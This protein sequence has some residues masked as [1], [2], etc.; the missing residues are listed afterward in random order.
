V[1]KQQQQQQQ[2]QASVSAML[3]SVKLGLAAAGCWPA[4][5]AAAPA[6]AGRA[7]CMHQ[8]AVPNSVHPG[9]AAAGQE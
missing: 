1:I 5:A 7:A 8:S 4:A 6:A 9:L 3:H 2:K